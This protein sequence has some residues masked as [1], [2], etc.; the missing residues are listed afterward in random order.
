LLSYGPNMSK[1]RGRESGFTLLEILVVLGIIG[2]VSAVSI[3]RI[4]EYVRQSRVRAAA[5][6]LGT[7]VNAARMKAVMKNANFGVVFVVQNATTYWIH[8]EDDLTLPKS[9]RQSLNMNA[10]DAAQSTRGRLPDGITF[11]TGAAQCPSLPSAAPAPGTTA[12]FPAIAAFAPNASAFRFTFLGARCKPDPADTTC[13]D[14]PIS[15][16][17][18]AVLAMNDATGNST[19]CLW[20]PRVGLSRAVTVASGGRVASQ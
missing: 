6:E 19:V 13:P 5:Q 20:D 3:P 10:P 12:L 2:V 7:Q 4:L 11:A 8:V 1:S 17:T 15:G 18:P 14:A 9:G 16:G